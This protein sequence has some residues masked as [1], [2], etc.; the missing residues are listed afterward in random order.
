MDENRIGYLL[1]RAHQAWRVRM[2][3][4]LARIELTA[5]QYTVLMVLRRK[6]WMSNADLARACAVAPQSMQEL[7]AGLVE[8]EL[9]SR[10][11]HAKNKRINELALTAKG[12]SKLVDA[13]MAF[14]L[15]EGEMLSGM[16]AAERRDFGRHL[17]RCSANLESYDERG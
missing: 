17:F 9:L 12:R 6:E 5:A 15:A 2:D 7:A 3:V 10:R 14:Q 4:R 13:D 1:R 11:A 16:R 8:A